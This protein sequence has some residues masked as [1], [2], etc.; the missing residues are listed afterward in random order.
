MPMNC[1]KLSLLNDTT[2][3]KNL[4]SSTVSEYINMVSYQQ[5]ICYVPQE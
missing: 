2:E 3:R 1:N 5:I 4:E